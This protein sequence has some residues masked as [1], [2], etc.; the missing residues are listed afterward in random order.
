MLGEGG[1]PIDETHEP[2]SSNF[3]Q[4]LELEASNGNP[5]A[6]AEIRKEITNIRSRS[7]GLELEV[8][9]KDKEI[10]LLRQRIQE[11][12]GQIYNPNQHVEEKLKVRLL[13]R[14]VGRLLPLKFT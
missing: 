1:L 7:E 12:G 14:V 9:Q 6:I 8:R 5:E 4:I 2:L 10:E 13:P 11:D 3:E